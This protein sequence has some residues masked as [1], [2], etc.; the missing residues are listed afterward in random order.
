MYASRT[1]KKTTGTQVII[2]GIADSE[3]AGEWVIDK[4]GSLMFNKQYLVTVLDICNMQTFNP[5][6]GVLKAVTLLLFVVKAAEAPGVV[7][8]TFCC[9]QPLV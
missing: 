1:R 7:S 2:L 8:S 6:Y 4:V 3:L 9:V 5:S